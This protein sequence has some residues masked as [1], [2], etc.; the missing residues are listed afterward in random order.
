[1]LL[2]G[3]LPPDVRRSMHVDLRAACVACLFSAAIDFIRVILRRLGAN[4]TLIA[5]YYAINA[6]GLTTTSRRVW[7]MRR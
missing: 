1:M 6:I 7:L 4:D 3:P 2:V 5:V